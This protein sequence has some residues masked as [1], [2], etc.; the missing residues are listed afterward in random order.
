VFWPHVPV[1]RN[2]TFFSGPDK[3]YPGTSRG[4]AGVRVSDIKQ[5]YTARGATVVVYDDNNREPAVRRSPTL[6]SN[7][8]PISDVRVLIVVVVVVVYR[9]VTMVDGIDALYCLQNR[10][11]VF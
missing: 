4:V 10:T 11:I 5:P 3:R 2:A 6:V 9:C 7:I 1:V 8:S